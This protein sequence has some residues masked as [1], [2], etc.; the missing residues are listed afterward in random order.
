MRRGRK[1]LHPRRRQLDGQ[2]QPVQPAA[3]LRHRR[4]VL[5]V[6]RRSPAGRPRPAPRTG[7][8]P[9]ARA[10]AAGAG[11]RRAG[12]GRPA[13]GARG[14]RCSPA[15]RRGSRLVART[16]DARAGRQQGGR[17]RRGTRQDVLAVVQHQQ[18]APGAAAWSRERRR[19]VLARRPPA[20]PA[21]AATA[22]GTSAG[23]A[24]G[25]RS[26]SHAPSGNGR[27]QHVGGGL[28]G[29]PGLARARRAGQGQQ[30][31]R[32]PAG[33]PTARQLGLPPDRSGSAGAGRLWGRAS[34]RA[35]G[36]EVR[37]AA[38]GAA[39][40]NTRSGRRQVLQPVL[41]PGR[42][43]RP[44]R[45][46]RPAPA[47]GGRRR[48]PSAPR[49]RWPSGARS[50]TGAPRSSAAA[51]HAPPPPGAAPSAPAAAPSRPRAPA[52][53]AAAPPG[54]PPRRRWG[55]RRRRRPRPPPSRTPPRR[56]PP[57]APWSRAWWRATAAR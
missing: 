2:G 7:P 50:G 10:S 40:W 39:S 27:R 23:S 54:R 18:Q 34:R 56:A 11:V 9:R 4:G 12:L 57:T 33:A 20:R 35:Q 3:D 48:A 38:P 42:A 43:G 46:G 49:G 36:R 53:R 24:S 21:P 14:A 28:Q 8:P 16:R 55:G 47:G 37:P 1:H 31:A 44:R 17:Q 29:Q 32:P 6:V 25:A 26:T 22:A 41:R 5:G 19:H 45:A 52:C 51:L 15:T 13:A 30:A